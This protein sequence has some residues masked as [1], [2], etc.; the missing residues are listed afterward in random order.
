M[1]KTKHVEKNIKGKT[2]RKSKDNK[3]NPKVIDKETQ[4]HELADIICNILLKE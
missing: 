2:V 3:V 4:L 1:K